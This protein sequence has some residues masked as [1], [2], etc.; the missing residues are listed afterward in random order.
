MPRKI[1]I[2]LLSKEI[3]D[4]E[5]N[6]IEIIFDLPD[7][8]IPSNSTISVVNLWIGWFNMGT[9]PTRNGSYRGP[10]RSFSATLSCS[11]VDFEI[12]N[13]DQTILFFSDTTP[14]CT[15]VSPTHLIDYK[16]RSSLLNSAVFKIKFN[17][18]KEK[19]KSD[20]QTTKNEKEKAKYKA[21][22]IEKIRLTLLLD[23]RL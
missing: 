16:I 10:T 7:I 22:Y 19:P 3:R 23:A 18:A 5:N 11:L 9:T 1:P 4:L 15:S 17:I 8:S 12:N 13:F 14:R 2:Q 20:R 21:E 6:Q